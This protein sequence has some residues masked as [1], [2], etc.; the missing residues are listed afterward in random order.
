MT[1]RPETPAP[2]DCAICER[3]AVWVHSFHCAQ[4]VPVPP[5][6]HGCEQRWGSR[7]GAPGAFRDRRVLGVL[8][9]LATALGCFAAQIEWEEKH[10]RT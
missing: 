3:P 2:Y 1:I 5:V 7:V 10:G 6:C 9:A 8:S 4:N